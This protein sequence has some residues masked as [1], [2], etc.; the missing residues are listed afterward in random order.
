MRSDTQ[1]ADWYNQGENHTFQKGGVPRDPE[2]SDN[3][4]SKTRSENQSAT[5]FENHSESQGTDGWERS[6]EPQNVN[7]FGHDSEHRHSGSFRM[8][9]DPYGAGGDPQDTWGSY[10]RAEQPG[11]GDNGHGKT[12]TGRDVYGAHSEV[13]GT[14]EWSEEI[15]HSKA[16][17]FGQKSNHKGQQYKNYGNTNPQRSEHSD[18]R[19]YSV[20]APESSG[21]D[22]NRT[23]NRNR[24][25]MSHWEWERLR[26]RSDC[27][28][29]GGKEMFR[30]DQEHQDEVYLRNSTFRRSV[31]PGVRGSRRKLEIRS[32]RKDK[33]GRIYNIRRDKHIMLWNDRV[34]YKLI[35]KCRQKLGHVR[36]HTEIRTSILFEILKNQMRHSLQEIG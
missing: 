25:S 12:K 3:W 7:V 19:I 23:D 28:V 15:S 33:R 30:P 29:S 20:Y 18:T 36:T 10:E 8:R 35:K 11:T 4:E 17:G 26:G 34:Y 5:R 27:Q 32:C 21:Q 22:S 14:R 9:S 16:G 24:W 13:R 6:S 31:H 2:H 1:S